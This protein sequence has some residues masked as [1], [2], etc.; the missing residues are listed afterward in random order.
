MQKKRRARGL[1][2]PPKKGGAK[3]TDFPWNSLGPKSPEVVKELFV[4]E[5]HMI[6]VGGAEDICDDHVDE[7]TYK[8]WS[9]IGDIRLQAIV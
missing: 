7:R 9:L 5:E 3:L 1:H 4:T 8:I 2:F 6:G